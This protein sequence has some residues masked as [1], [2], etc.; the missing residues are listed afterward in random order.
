MPAEDLYDVLGLSPDA[1]DIVVTAAYKALAQRYHPDKWQGGAAEANIKMASINAAYSILRDS[2]KRA[3]YDKSRVGQGHS[4]YGSQDSSEKDQAF[5]DALGET[6]ERWKVACSLYPDLVMIR[7]ELAR[8]SVPLAFS[9]VVVLLGSKAF[10][11][12]AELA[13]RME[14]QFLERY[15]GSNNTLVKFARELIIDGEK[16]GA[17]KLNHLVD[18]VGSS[19]N[20]EH[21]IA[22]IESEL[23]LT[24][25]RERR[26]QERERSD[27]LRKLAQVVLKSGA[28]CDA[29]LL[30]EKCGYRVEQFRR[31]FFKVDGVALYLDGEK[32]ID[33]DGVRAFCKWITSG[34]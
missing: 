28:Y 19:A 6:E 15:F 9:F 16:E 34:L 14:R 21:V 24:K 23:P 7:S 31:G 13:K 29:K 17:R 8:I 1:E 18:V 26:L 27:E 32:K 5:N 20:P 10:E 25:R 11:K 30:A 4:S 33:F 2:T 12:R 22:T 3:D